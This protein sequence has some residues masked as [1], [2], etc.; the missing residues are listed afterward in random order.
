LMGGVLSLFAPQTGG[1]AYFGHLGGMIVG[2]ILLK[3]FGF[4]RRKVRFFWE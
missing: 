4:E 1:V 2:I 3:F